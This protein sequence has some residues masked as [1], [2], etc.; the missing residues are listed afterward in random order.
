MI[1]AEYPAKSGSVKNSRKSMPSVMYFSTVLSLVQS[2]NR[3]EYPT[4]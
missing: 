3:I 2:S 4:S 1:N